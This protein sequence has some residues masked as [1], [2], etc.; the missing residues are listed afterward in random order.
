MRDRLDRLGSDALVEDLF[1]LNIRGVRTI[2]TMPARPRSACEAAW[3]SPR[4][5]VWWF[6]AF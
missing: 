1:G 5:P 2:W 3:A 4:R 6:G